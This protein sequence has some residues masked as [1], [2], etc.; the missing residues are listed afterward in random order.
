MH[1]HRT[2]VCTYA[3]SDNSARTRLFLYIPMYAYPGTALRRV[4]MDI[5]RCDEEYRTRI[6]VVASRILTTQVP[7][8]LK[9]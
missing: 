7:G 9:A 2:R 1:M 5:S 3:Y 4:D 6:V 8:Y